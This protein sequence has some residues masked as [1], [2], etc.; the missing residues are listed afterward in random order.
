MYAW[1]VHNPTD[2]YTPCGI[3]KDEV[4]FIIVLRDMMEDCYCGLLEQSL[5][6]VLL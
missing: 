1:L 6:Q 3:V 4:E 2:V 5:L